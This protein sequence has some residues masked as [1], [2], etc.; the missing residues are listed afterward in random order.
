M[1]VV[2]APGG[3]IVAAP[4]PPPL[5]LH[6]RHRV[7]E[8]VLDERA[9]DEDHAEGVPAANG[10]ASQAFLVNSSSPSHLDF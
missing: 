4:P 3:A 1:V 7:D 6:A 10:A 2:V 9:E 8:G 5:H